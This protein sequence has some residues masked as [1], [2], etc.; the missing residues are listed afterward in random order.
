MLAS[1]H[2]A[3][4]LT[5]CHRGNAGVRH[6]ARIAASGKRRSHGNTITDAHMAIISLQINRKPKADTNTSKPA[7]TSTLHNKEN[8]ASNVSSHTHKPSSS[9]SAAALKP[10]RSS[11]ATS[12]A[13]RPQSVRASAVGASDVA[14]KAQVTEFAVAQAPSGRKRHSSEEAFLPAGLPCFVT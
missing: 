5:L 9:S 2:E 8:R 7:S 3:E 10:D 13:A 14:K 11:L 6:C 1:R 12:G 4:V